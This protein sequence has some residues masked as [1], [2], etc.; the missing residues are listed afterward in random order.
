[1]TAGPPGHRPTG[2][3]EAALDGARRLGARM[4]ELRAA[5]RLYGSAADDRR[6]AR[7][8][9]LR[10]VYETFTEGFGTTDLAEA[11]AA[12]DG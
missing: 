6:A 8:H 4:S 10:S 2:S 7:L 1:M 12:L 3:Y 9:D 11:R 5:T